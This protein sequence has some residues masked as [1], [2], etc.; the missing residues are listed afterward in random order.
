MIFDFMF[1]HFLVGLG[2]GMMINAIVFQTSQTTKI[3]FWLNWPYNFNSTY[4]ALK[5]SRKSISI[6][7]FLCF[8]ID[9]CSFNYIWHNKGRLFS[10]LRN[11]S[12]YY[13]LSVTEFLG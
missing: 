12:F 13:Q 3:W 4:N 6:S 11:Y 1:F 7:Y 5:K 10:F 9:N 8:L 2:K